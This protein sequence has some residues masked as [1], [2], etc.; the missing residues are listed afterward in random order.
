LS[1][2]AT[3]L[4]NNA[5]YTSQIVSRGLGTPSADQLSDGLEL[6]NELLSF[7]AVN[8]RLIPYY[9]TY[10]LT[11]VAGQ[12]VYFIPNLIEIDS[13]TFNMGS[14]RFPTTNQKRKRYFGSGRA[15]N[16]N[17][18]PVTWHL[19]RTKGGANLYLYFKPDTTYPLNL[20]GKF[21]FTSVTLSNDLST[22]YDS[23]YISYLKY[24]LAEYICMDNAVSLPP[25]QS[26]KLAEFKQTILDLS[27]LD[28]SMEKQST[29]QR[30][31]NFNYAD[32]NIGRGWRP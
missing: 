32:V 8:G 2:T 23:Y 10:S 19:E 29:L 12:E 11:A 21:G 3:K 25:Q 27:P 16:I 31:S 14:V 28:L 24:S 5:Y 9:Q 26:I 22:V 17:S 13:F 30:G 20:I 7:Q 18:L 15:N 1:Y 4:I 6:L